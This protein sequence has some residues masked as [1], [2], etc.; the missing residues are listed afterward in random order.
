MAS[1][2][3]NGQEFRVEE[4]A[5]RGGVH[6]VSVN[7]NQVAID[8]LK[9]VAAD[10][11]EL[12]LRVGGKI[13]RVVVQNSN[14]LGN[15]VELNGKPLQANLGLVEGLGQVKRKEEVAGPI[16]ITAPMSGR[17]ASLKVEAGTRAEEGQSLVILEAMKMENE[18]TS[19]R[20]GIV[21]EVYVRAGAL[22]KAGDKLALVE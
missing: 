8:V 5:R 18:I 20:R 14:E 1:L 15:P 3:L 12:I 11:F 10:P 19:P 7:G 22:V 2:I 13:F 6:I 17:I 4:V 16:I 21:K 9:E